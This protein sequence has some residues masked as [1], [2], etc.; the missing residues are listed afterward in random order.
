VLEDA[1]LLSIIGLCYILCILQHFLYR[2]RF[3]Q[4]TV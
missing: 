2:G 1:V 4:D 3:F